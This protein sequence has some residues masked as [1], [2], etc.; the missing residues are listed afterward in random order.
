MGPGKSLGTHGTHAHIP[1]KK[2]VR[3]RRVGPH[4][5]DALV[6]N[7]H[8]EWCESKHKEDV[9]GTDN[10]L[11]HLRVQSAG[12]LLPT[13]PIRVRVTQWRTRPIPIS[14]TVPQPQLSTITG[15]S[16]APPVTFVAPPLRPD[17]VHR[18]PRGETVPKLQTELLQ[19]ALVLSLEAVEGYG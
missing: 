7:D 18:D 4:V 12:Q 9:Q 15:A 3:Q 16:A 8:D 2:Y 11:P 13:P 14:V 17:A 10:R 5:W 19:L 6:H 1:V